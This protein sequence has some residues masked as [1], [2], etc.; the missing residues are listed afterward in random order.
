MG[1]KNIHNKDREGYA[2]GSA[3][4]VSYK[5][6]ENGTTETENKLTELSAGACNVVGSHKYCAEHYTARKDL[7]KCKREYVCAAW[8]NEKA[9]NKKASEESNGNM[10]RDDT[11]Y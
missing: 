4:P 11:S 9:E 2:F 1:S 5:E 7:R 3:G 8:G 10:V 6:G